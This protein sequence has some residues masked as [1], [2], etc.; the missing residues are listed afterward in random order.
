MCVMN[1]VGLS[2]VSFQRLLLGSNCVVGVVPLACM[3]ACGGKGIN[4]HTE[5]A[6]Q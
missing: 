3:H 6:K 5:Q 4:W 2:G 1:D